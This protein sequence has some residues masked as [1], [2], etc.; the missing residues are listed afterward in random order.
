MS[1]FL[2]DTDDDDNAAAG[3]DNTWT[4]LRKQQN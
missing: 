3:Y 4:F 2:H 1:K